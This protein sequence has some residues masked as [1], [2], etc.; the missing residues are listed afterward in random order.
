MTNLRVINMIIIILGIF[1]II[2]PA[3]FCSTLPPEA[4]MT[5]DEIILYY[6]YPA[7]IFH[8]YTTDGYILDLH[9]I[10]FG[11]NGYSTKQKH[12]PVILLQHGLLGSSTDWVGNL[13]NQSSGRVF[14]T[15]KKHSSYINKSTS[16]TVL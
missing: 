3:H 12:R 16:I 7:Q 10:P 5:T 2:T 14:I 15:S 8:A 13:P 4:K 6:G 9:R 1:L 11:R